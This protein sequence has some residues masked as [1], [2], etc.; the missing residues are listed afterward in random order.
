V[1]DE[2]IGAFSLLLLFIIFTG[3]IDKK[4]DGAGHASFGKIGKRSGRRRRNSRYHSARGVRR[5]GRTGDTQEEDNQSDGGLL[6]TINRSN[7]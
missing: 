5:Q 1:S 4:D 3:L 7:R 2:Y 6:S